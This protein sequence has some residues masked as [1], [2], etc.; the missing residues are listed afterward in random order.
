MLKSDDKSLEIVFGGDLHEID[1]D[2]L[3]E[4]LV[5]YSLITQETVAYLSPGAQVNIKIKALKQGSFKVL[6]DLIAQ[7]GVFTAEN[8]GIAAGI[9]TIVGGLYK[10]KKWIA[11]NGKPESVRPI[12]EHN[13]EVSNNRGRITINNNVYNIY[14][15]NSKVREKLRDTF[16]RLKENKD[17]TGFSI[18]DVVDGKDIFSVEKEDFS[19]LASSN[20][21][22]EQRKQK[23][24]QEK[25]ELIVFKIVFQDKYKW[26]FVYQGRKISASIK[27]NDF[28]NKI[29]K[30]AI[31]FRS[32]DRLIVDLEIEQIFNE[33]VN[34]FINSGS[35]YILK[36]AEHIPR[37]PV[38]QL[39]LDF[40][41]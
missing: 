1:A 15:E 3:I 23:V 5:N 2:L 38:S 24:I 20:D 27:D 11:K 41:D 34:S 22:V 18:R 17:I 36:V 21:E 16:L 25:Q 6:L 10:F 19:L 39:S 30:G 26:E 32:G 8:I 7:N 37:A 31:A 29:E 33:A 40:E 28:F 14:Q 35:Y 4:S 12:G 13:I 9:V